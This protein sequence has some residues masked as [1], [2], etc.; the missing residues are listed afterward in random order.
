MVSHFPDTVIALLNA[1][2][3]PAVDNPTDI[4]VFNLL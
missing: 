4:L 3:N 2:Q 1:A